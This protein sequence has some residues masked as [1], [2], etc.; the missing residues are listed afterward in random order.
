[1]FFLFFNA[2]ERGRRFYPQVSAEIYK[3]T[4]EIRIR[5]VQQSLVIQS[6]VS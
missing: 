6:K 5:D 4:A 1:V 3:K 2:N